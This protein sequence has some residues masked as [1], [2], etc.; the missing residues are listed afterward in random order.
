VSQVQS[1]P[2]TLLFELRHDLGARDEAMRRLC[3]GK[4]NCRA[5]PYVRKY[6]SEDNQVVDLI[7]KIRYGCA[8]NAFNPKAHK[9]FM[10]DE[11]VCR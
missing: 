7:V 1:R 11:L 4:R 5:K 10:N 8:P 6:L 9:V 3:G 2:E